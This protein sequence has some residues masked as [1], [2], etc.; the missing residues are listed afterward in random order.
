MTSG[1]RQ[2]ILSLF[3]PLSGS[4]LT[5]ANDDSDKENIGPPRGTYLLDNFLQSIREPYHTA[6]RI[7]KKRLVDIGD[8]TIEDAFLPLLEDEG[9]DDDFTIDIVSADDDEDPTL[10][11]KDMAKAATP[12]PKPRP[13]APRTP[14]GDL[15]IEDR[16]TPAFKIDTHARPSVFLKDPRTVHEIHNVKEVQHNPSLSSDSEIPI[17]ISPP[18]PSSF[19]LSS[20]TVY[21]D[22]NSSLRPNKAQSCNSANRLSIDLQTSFQLQLQSPEVTFDLLNDKISFFNSKDGMDSFL[23]AL[24]EDD[25]SYVDPGRTIKPFESQAGGKKNDISFLQQEEKLQIGNGEASSSEDSPARDADFKKFPSNQVA[26]SSTTTPAAASSRISPASLISEGLTGNTA[27]L[28]P[29]VPALKIVKRPMIVHGGRLGSSVTLAPS[30]SSYASR[31]PLPVRQ[32]LET[33][34]HMLTSSFSNEKDIP[35]TSSFS[36]IEK[37]ITSQPSA[38]ASVQPRRDV[39]PRRV[40]VSQAPPP[41]SLTQGKT[42]LECPS[43]LSNGPRRVPIAPTVCKGSSSTTIS[44]SGQRPSPSSTVVS[45]G[46]PKPTLKTGIP[47]LTSGSHVGSGRNGSM[48]KTTIPARRIL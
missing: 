18:S 42:N 37:R 29:S 24:E 19:S 39:G 43:G 40:L 5:T 13:T 41:S 20:T 21:C 46:L 9:T 38:K 25:S 35:S 3:D 34:T 2:S 48:K 32:T 14:L 7:P 28:L 33:A 1:P 12:S 17:H 11:F 10:T 44:K 22:T 26:I 36:M 6:P 23:E 45:S 47:R 4:P 31:Q 15:P 30:Q 16:S 8:M 27:P